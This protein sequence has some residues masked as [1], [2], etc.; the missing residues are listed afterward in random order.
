MRDYIKLKWFFSGPKKSVNIK[1]MEP[2]VRRNVN[3][4]GH[5]G[6]LDEDYYKIK[7]K[8]TF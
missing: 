3:C 6:R 5:W 4:H 8:T 7:N 1:K 2:R